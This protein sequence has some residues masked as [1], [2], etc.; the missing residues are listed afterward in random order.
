MLKVPCHGPPCCAHNSRH[1]L[2][3]F[4]APG[5]AG[6]AG[7]RLAAAFALPAAFFFDGSN[8]SLSL[9]S[10]ADLLKKLSRG[11]CFVF[12]FEAFRR[13]QYLSTRSAWKLHCST[14][15]F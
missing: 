8:L 7:P 15:N 13:S 11:R 9:I 1:L 5:P 10:T 2:A 4:A 14:R 6:V 12:D 3:L